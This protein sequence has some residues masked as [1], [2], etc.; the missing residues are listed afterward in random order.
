M[1]KKRQRIEKVHCNLP[2]IPLRERIENKW[3]IAVSS[4]AKR[5]T[6]LISMTQQNRF[7]LIKSL[8]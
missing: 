1:K 4:K 3:A 5:R 8:Y 2:L 7:K 6:E